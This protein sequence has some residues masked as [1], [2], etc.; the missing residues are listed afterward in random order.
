MIWW[1]TNVDRSSS[2][3][4]SSTP[5]TTVVPAADEVSEAIAL[6]INSRLS[7][8]ADSAHEE[9]APNGIDRAEDVP[10]IHRTSHPC[11]SAELS[12]SR[13]IR[14]LPTPAAPQTT[15]P[16]RLESK[17]AASISRCFLERPVHGPDKRPRTAH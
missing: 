3:A 14:L 15:T 4:T 16:A 12:A 17:I 5:S 13:A 11:D 8:P 2:R 10:T 1:T 7:S 9:S 6:R